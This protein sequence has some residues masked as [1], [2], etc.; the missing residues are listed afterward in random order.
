MHAPPAGD[1]FG[2]LFYF[3]TRFDIALTVFGCI[4]KLVFGSLQVRRTRYCIWIASRIASIPTAPSP[5]PACR[6]EGTI[7]VQTHP[8]FV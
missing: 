7:S 1:F 3:A 4:C 5:L 2:S 8:L 6:A